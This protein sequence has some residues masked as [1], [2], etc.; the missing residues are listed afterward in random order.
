MSSRPEREK[1][2]N[3]TKKK[4]TKEKSKEEKREQCKKERQ[5]SVDLKDHDGVAFKKK[6]KKKLKKVY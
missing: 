1:K 2:Q 3:K 5:T 4:K 6:D